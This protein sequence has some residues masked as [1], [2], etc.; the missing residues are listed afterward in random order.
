M[1]IV[2][3]VTQQILQL[4]QIDADIAIKAGVYARPMAF[5]LLFSGFFDI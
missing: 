4:F 3:M 5:A 1:L 2:V